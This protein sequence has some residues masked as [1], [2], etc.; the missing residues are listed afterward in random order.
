MYV[1]CVLGP[2][3]GNRIHLKVQ[4]YGCVERLSF[5][6]EFIWHH[7]L[8][9]R[10]IFLFLLF[11]WVFTVYV[12]LYFEVVCVCVWAVWRICHTICSVDW[13]RFYFYFI[14]SVVLVVANIIFTIVCVCT[15]KSVEIPSKTENATKW[16]EREWKKKKSFGPACDSHGKRIVYKSCIQHSANVKSTNNLIEAFFPWRCFSNEITTYFHR[17]QQFHNTRLYDDANKQNHTQ[18][19]ITICKMNA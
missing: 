7:V 3:Y 15:Q 19:P 1:Y 4:G 13:N 6:S 14:F 10:S 18:N 12:Q 17:S 8:C 11:L 9:S 5:R 16:E 2:S